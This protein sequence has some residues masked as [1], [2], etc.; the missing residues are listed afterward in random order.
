MFHLKSLAT[1]VLH[2]HV[3][4]QHLQT[5]LMELSISLL[6]HGEHC[7]SI[8]AGISLDTPTTCLP[9]KFGA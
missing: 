5:Q 3:Q 9:P 2:Q 8:R 4:L 7:L 1:F 6:P